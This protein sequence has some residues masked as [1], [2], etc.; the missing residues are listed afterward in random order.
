[1]DFVTKNGYIL[2]TAE[3]EEKTK[4]TKKGGGVAA[5]LGLAKDLMD[6]QDKV[7]AC[8]EAQDITE[9][10]QKIESHAT[11]LSKMYED[12]LDIA[13][14]GVKSIRENANVETVGEEPKQEMDAAPA[15]AT[16][17]KSMIQSPSIPSLKQ[18]GI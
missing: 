3:L 8:C 18:M 2:R 12:L 14:A 7:N 10:K 6:F 16:S 5:I 11:A 13:K 9:N 17:E 1:M 15:P 4:K